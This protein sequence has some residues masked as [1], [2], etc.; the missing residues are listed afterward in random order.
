MADPATYQSAPASSGSGSGMGTMD[1]VS[2]LLKST[3]GSHYVIATAVIGALVLLVL[4]LAWKLHGKTAAAPAK[5]SSFVNNSNLSSGWQ[6]GG[7]HA[8]G[9]GSTMDRPLTDYHRELTDESL[10]P[11]CDEDGCGRTPRGC[12]LY[13]ATAEDEAAAASLLNGGGSEGQSFARMSSYLAPSSP[14]TEEYLASHVLSN[15][16]E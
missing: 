13:S 6:R 8:G 12:G 4:V 15:Q 14:K 11:R 5:A 1:H 3:V 2:A 16:A 10:R 7:L 9:E